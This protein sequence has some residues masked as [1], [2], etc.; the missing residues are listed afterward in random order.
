M[1]L[2]ACHIRIWGVTSQ[3]DGRLQTSCAC[4]TCQT[5]LCPSIGTKRDSGWTGRGHI[6]WSHCLFPLTSI[7]S[8][9]QHTN[10]KG[11]GQ[12]ACRSA[13]GLWGG[14]V[15]CSASLCVSCSLV[16]AARFRCWQRGCFE[17]TMWWH[18]SLVEFSIKH[19]QKRGS[20]DSGED[21]IFGE[22]WLID[23]PLMLST[24]HGRFV[25]GPEVLNCWLMTAFKACQG[26]PEHSLWSALG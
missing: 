4:T 24:F 13:S 16:W 18:P 6:D 5:T 11:G 22:A 25:S 23:L 3:G 19:R 10:R 12:K 21:Y 20:V 17:R 15:S 14:R 1:Y 2:K 7:D 9:C 8:E 26:G